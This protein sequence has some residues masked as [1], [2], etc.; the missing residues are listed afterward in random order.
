MMSSRWPLPIGTRASTALRP[1]CI[2]SWTDC[3]GMIPGALSSTLC[4]SLE[5][6]GPSPSMGLPRAS[7][8]LPRRPS[9][10]GTSTMEP[11]LLT[12]SPSWISLSLPKTTIPTLSVSRLRAIPLTPEVNS[13]ISPA[14]TLVKPKTRAIPSPMEIT[15]PNSFKSLTWEIPETFCWRMV[16]ASPM[17]G[18]LLADATAE[19]RKALVVKLVSWC[20]WTAVLAR[21]LENILKIK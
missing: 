6:M 20:C 1:V 7:I 14:W 9:P 19:A 5:S 2:G 8:T 18:F 17:E 21:Y 10:K 16:T 3:L 15:V 4:L 12:I 11:V 13:T